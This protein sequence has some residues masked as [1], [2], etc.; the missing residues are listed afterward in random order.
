MSISAILNDAWKRLKQDGNNPA[1]AAV[2]LVLC[3][4]PLPLA[5]NSIALGVL[6]AVAISYFYRYR[7]F[8]LEMTMIYP[9][10]LF[11]L[12]ALSISW[13]I[14]P[15]V[16]VKALSKELMLLIVPLCFM[17]FPVLT[18]AQKQRM[19]GYYSYAMTIFAGFCLVRAGVRFVIS[20][21]SSVFF[22][23]ELVTK[24]VNAIHVSIYFAI[25]LLWFM[26][27]NIKSKVQQLACVVLLVSL[28]LLS[29][30]NVIIVFAFLAFWSVLR[31]RTSPRTRL[32]IIIAAVLGSAVLF[33][34]D[35]V[36][37][38]FMEEISTVGT[39]NTVNSGY[40]DGPV[41][42]KS[43]RE[44]WENE[45]FS[46]SDY[47]PGTALRV[48]QAR[49]FLELLH[50][51]PIFWTGYGLNAS[52]G[53][54]AEKVRQYNMHQGYSEFNFHNQYIQN[55]ADLGVF[56][57]L[58]LLLLLG[59]S[60]YHGFRNKDFVHISFTV[61]MISLFL[62]ESFLWRQRGVTFFTAMYCLF[63]SGTSVPR[64]YLKK[65]ASL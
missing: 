47:F 4:I 36:K 52:Y 38:R 57:F 9:I 28:V 34:S 15:A 23:H 3:C 26:T 61:L 7:F 65:N 54:I 20:G 5:F 32:V 40:A 46:P 21:D 59:V 13:S 37:S 30:K 29:S 53:K 55:F 17:L 12:M 64:A 56:G 22:Y 39:D 63:N 50:E 24:L 41:Y 10:L 51:D 25:A 42:N 11:G 16:S 58:L 14:E 27:N 1:L 35:A 45:R 60:L 6:G 44:A 8:R 43:I 62:T 48:L 18:Q 2:L 19:L 49:F 33:T 31:K